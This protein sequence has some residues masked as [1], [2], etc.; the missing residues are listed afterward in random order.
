MD[1]PKEH[2]DTP[3]SRPAE[4]EPYGQL[5]KRN[6]RRARIARLLDARRKRPGSVDR[7]VQLQRER[8]LRQGR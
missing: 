2:R 7:V 4:R 1:A 5:R 6:E 8:D 3:A